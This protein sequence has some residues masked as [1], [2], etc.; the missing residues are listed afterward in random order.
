ML[1]ITKDEI[2]NK[3]IYNV[4]S[5]YVTCKICKSI[6]QEASLCTKCGYLACCNCIK[7]YIKTNLNKTPCKCNQNFIISPLIIK[8]INKL[9]FKCHNGCGKDNL[10]FNDLKEH[11]EKFCEKIPYNE[12]YSKLQD[13]YNEIEK[14]INEIKASN[15]SDSIVNSPYHKHPLTLCSIGRNW[16]CNNCNID[17]K[18][19]VMTY[20]CSVC[21]FSLCRRCKLGI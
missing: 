13:K 20:Y 12:L 17:Y 4:I 2:S 5:N 19:N 6:V 8:S 1:K 10:K 14:I 15:Q 16:I 7:N 9:L 18:S 11:Y 3:E 21:D